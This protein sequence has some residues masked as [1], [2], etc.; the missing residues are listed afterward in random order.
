MRHD[1]TLTYGGAQRLARIITQYWLTR[2]F[3]VD[4]IVDQVS[5]PHRPIMWVVRSTM[6]NGHPHRKVS[7]H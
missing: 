4:V 3:E 5:V 2:G 1:D 6:L 7:K